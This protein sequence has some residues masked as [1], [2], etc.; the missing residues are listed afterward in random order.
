MSLSD[1]LYKIRYRAFVNCIGGDRADIEYRFNL[2][3]KH[4]YL[5]VE[6][7]KV[8]CTTIKAVLQGAE[9]RK[10][11]QVGAD[12]I[13]NRGQSP[14]HS[15]KNNPKLFFRILNSE[16]A[17]RFTF[18]RNPYTRLLS[19]YLDKIRQKP[20]FDEWRVRRLQQLSLPINENI[21]FHDFVKS[22]ENADPQKMDAHWRPQVLLIAQTNVHYNFIGRFENLNEDIKNVARY[23]GFSDSLDFIKN[24]HVTNSDQKIKKYYNKELFKMVNEIFLDDF[25]ELNYD[26]IK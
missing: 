15:P 5:Y 2:S 24:P 7:P 16:S 18:V 8:A 1:H 3:E 22:L 17:Y 23:L 13:H 10:V 19:A 20:I 26:I 4:Q 9:G 14:L 11:D 6:T 12:A 25:K 21:S